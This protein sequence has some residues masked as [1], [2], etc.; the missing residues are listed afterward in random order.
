[1]SSGTVEKIRCGQCI[2]DNGVKLQVI[3]V[4]VELA[5]NKFEFSLSNFTKLNE[6]SIKV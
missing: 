5:F 3:V 6:N 1:M 4:E 2:R